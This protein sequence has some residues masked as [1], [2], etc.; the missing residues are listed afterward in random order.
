MTNEN[1]INAN[2]LNATKST[3]PRT[4]EGKAKVALNALKHGLSARTALLPDEDEEVFAALRAGLLEDL[5]PSGAV[6]EVLASEIVDLAWRLQR[7]SRVE[8]GLFILEQAA[9]EEDRVNAEITK[10]NVRL[11]SALF[12]N[13]TRGGGLQDGIILHDPDGDEEL[14]SAL[15]E[16]LASERTPVSSLAEAFGRDA[17]RANAFSKLGRYEGTLARRLSRKLAELLAIQA[18]RTDA[19]A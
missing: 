14:R 9:A 17:A 16:T 8:A 3:G 10:L 12:S 4:K 1:R 5:K 19:D 15:A 2:R 7:A 18:A 13:E 11:L 6:E